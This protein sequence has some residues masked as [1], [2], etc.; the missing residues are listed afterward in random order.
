V[1]YSPSAPSQF[2]L[3]LMAQ[4]VMVIGQ[5]LAGDSAGAARVSTVLQPAIAASVK[6]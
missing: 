4:N 3:S 1:T 2:N 6:P 5:N